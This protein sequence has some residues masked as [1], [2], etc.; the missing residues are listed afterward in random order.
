VIKENE[1]MPRHK[2]AVKRSRQNKRRAERNKAQL[3]KVKTLIKKVRNA[4]EKKEA[5]EALKNATKYLDHLAA[6]YS[7]KSEIKAYQVCEQNEVNRTLYAVKKEPAPMRIEF[8]CYSKYLEN[9]QFE[10]KSFYFISRYSFFDLF[11]FNYSVL[12]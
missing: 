8:F 1:G 7:L 10:Q 3:S 4:K 5:S 9:N 11:V 12:N 6:A 2:S